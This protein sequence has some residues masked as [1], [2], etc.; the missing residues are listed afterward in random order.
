M[1]IRF[2][3]LTFTNQVGFIDDFL[4]FGETEKEHDEALKAVIE[5]LNALGIQLNHHKC[6]FRQTEV[7]FLGHKLSA[8]GVRPSDDKVISI[9]N[10][11]V[12]STK[13]ELR[14][15]LGLVTFVSRFIP[16]LATANSPLRELIKQS[17]KFEWN[18]SHQEAFNTIK[19]RIGSMNYLG[20]F[21]PKDR[22]LVVADA[23][24]VGLG[25]VLIQ[26]KG[27]QP[28]VIS[29]ASKSLT[30][31]EKKYPPIEKEALGIV[32]AVERFR[33]YLLGITF[34]LETDH[35]PLES[36]FTSTSR[37]TLRI[38]RWLLRLQGFRF[39]VVYRKGSANLADPLSRMASHV[40]DKHWQEESEVYIR[41]VVCTF[42]STL[43]N[44]S[45]EEFDAETE[46]VIRSVQVAA[47]VDISEVIEATKRD[48]ELSAVVEA[49]MTS[50]WNSPKVK[51]FAPF[52]N[53]LSYAYGVVI[54]GAKL[55]IPSVLRDRMCQLAHEG[56]PGQEVMKSR[57]RERC[58][59]PLMDR[60]AVKVCDSCEGCRL[61]QVEAPPEPMNRRP[62]PDKPWVDLAI[63]FLGPMPTGEY[64]LVVVDYYSRYM[65]LEVMQKIT[66]QETVTRLKKLFRTWGNPRTITLDN[67]RQFISRE[68]GDFCRSM[69]IVL[70]H[71][72]PYWPQANGQVERQNRSLSKRLKISNALHGDWKK[73]LDDYLIL[74]NNAPHCV[75]GKAP[76]ELLLG[77]KLRHKIPQIDDLSTPVLGSDFRD[78]DTQ[79]KFDDKT[80]E[81]MKRG[82]KLSDIQAGDTVL[83]KNLHPQDKL[84]TNFGKEQFVVK[85][86]RGSN[87]TIQSKDTDKCYDRNVSHLKKIVEPGQS[88]DDSADSSEDLEVQRPL[89]HAFGQGESSSK[90]QTEGRSSEIRRSSRVVK[91]SLRYSP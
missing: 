43:G 60:Q 3:L 37:P 50:H 82:S 48:E 74:Y 12:P 11:R 64:I 41:R 26:F 72:T 91:P 24:G 19:E 61:V 67:G 70:N 30:E 2:H 17:A 42:L 10:C 58:W 65:E 9:L 7:I 63:D 32:W 33:I 1:V 68:F 84:S 31:T 47:A 79:R 44:D 45:L 28:R 4:V 5:R 85:D 80:R 46:Q 62:M 53:E 89:R 71:S 75:T 16:D 22:T 35:R 21:D 39:V 8:Q 52:Q 78:R 87:V 23:S 69:G 73:E 38:E 77:R 18:R 86:K 90:Q 6:K 25:A 34:E 20:Y 57:L 55:V 29:Y 59:W 56:H 88:G 15:F 51:A 40:D 76:S 49:I 27:H 13:E 36:I 54:R 81:D 14:S 83:M 66:A